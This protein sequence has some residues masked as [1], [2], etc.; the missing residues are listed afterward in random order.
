VQEGFVGAPHG[1]EAGEQVG[2]G[3]VEVRG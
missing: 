3:E 2:D 1:D